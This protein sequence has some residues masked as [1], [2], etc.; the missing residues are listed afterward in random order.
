MNGGYQSASHTKLLTDEERAFLQ[1][2]LGLA[3]GSKAMTAMD[4]S[5]VE[6]NTSPPTI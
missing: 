5:Q 6:Q 1:A 4:G 3:T 2:T